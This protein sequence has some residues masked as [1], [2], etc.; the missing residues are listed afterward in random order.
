MPGILLENQG[1][2]CFYM[3]ANAQL[4]GSDSPEEDVKE[5]PKNVSILLKSN[6]TK[7][8][9][10]SISGEGSTNMVDQ[11]YLYV[12]LDVYFATIC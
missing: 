3:H 12:F 8:V 11:T 9:L 10:S 5:I 4:C 6:D 7:H 2:S 1:P